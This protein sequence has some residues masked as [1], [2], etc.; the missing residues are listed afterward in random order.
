[1]LQEKEELEADFHDYRREVERTREGVAVKEV[2]LLKAMVKN[3]EEDLLKERTKN[4]RAASKR[5][6]EYRQML[7]EVCN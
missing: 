7:E 3:L 5:S 6:Q 4:Q 2:R 1:M